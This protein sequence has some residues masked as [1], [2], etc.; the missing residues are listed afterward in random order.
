MNSPKKILLIIDLDNADFKIESDLKLLAKKSD[1]K[2]QQDIELD[3]LAFLDVSNKYLIT[4]IKNIFPNTIINIIP[5][6]TAFNQVESYVI[7][8]V[9]R[10][11]SDLRPKLFEIATKSVNES[12]ANR[13]SELWWYTRL[14]E[15]NSPVDFLWWKLMYTE[16]IRRRISQG[17]YHSCLLIGHESLDYLVCQL[18]HKSLTNYNAIIKEQEKLL[19]IKSGIWRIMGFFSLAFAIMYSKL[20][21]IKQYR[22]SDN[23]ENKDLIFAYSWFPRVWVSRND[24]FQDMYYGEGINELAKKKNKCP[25]FIMRLFDRSDY[26]SP[27]TY[28]KRCQRLQKTEILN[29]KFLLLE[30]FGSILETIYNYFSLGDLLRF[31]RMSRNKEFHES[32]EWNGINIYKSCSNLIWKSAIVFWPHLITLESFSKKLSTTHVPSKVLLYCFEFIYGKSIINGTLK[33]N[34]NIEVI[35]LQH[36]PITPMKFMYNGSPDDLIHKE[37]SIAPSPLPNRFIVDGEVSSKVLQ[38]SGIGKESINI[39]GPVR[40]K[41]IWSQNIIR[42]HSDDKINILVAPGLHDSEFLIDFSIKALINKPNFNIIIKPHPKI[43]IKKI[44]RILDNYDKLANTFAN[45]DLVI[46]GSIYSYFNKVDYFITTYSSTGVEAIAFDV[47]ILMIISKRIPD[48]SLYFGENDV[49][50]KA[51]NKIELV[52]H[53]DNLI[54]NK[55]FKDDYLQKLKQAFHR[56]FFIRGNSLEGFAN[57]F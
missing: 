52:N 11:F 21:D 30:S 5:T 37:K 24:H 3:V 34:D 27:M 35:G 28:I 51:G 7:Q 55:S 9:N 45:V 29:H 43:D 36:G 41:D 49:A 47:P 33:A 48:M 15:K 46:E 2:F 31:L 39:I 17:S 16:I 54:V 50:L 25:I 23:E 42:K 26:V 53:I 14:T 40:F 13:F 19:I 57:N 32:F 10:L 8:S 4:S 12:W 56:S 6:Y 22:Y 44:V 38:K 18:F 1:L 20:I